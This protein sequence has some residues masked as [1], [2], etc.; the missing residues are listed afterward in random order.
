[1]QKYLEKLYIPP[2]IKKIKID[3]GLS[4]NA[5]ISHKLLEYEDD[6]F[7]FG[8]EPN[9]DSIDNI[10]NGNLKN[11][12]F[13]VIFNTKNINR[14]FILPIAL[15]NVTQKKNVLFHKTIID[16]GT[17]SLYKPI[18]KRL[19]KYDTT[20]VEVFSLKHFFDLFDW[21][22]FPYI[23]WI[24]ID[25]QGADL[26]IIKSAKNYLKERVVYVTLEPENTQY[27]NINQNTIEN[28][29]DYILSNNFIY[30]NHPNTIDPTYLN[31]K[32]IYLKDTVYL[33]QW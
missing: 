29:S 13:P 9:I 21:N 6:V 12:N 10:K 15:D 27:E 32:F 23:E 28:I 2:H 30:I 14:L 18:D 25:A 22:R 17:S 7:I 8:F 3:I 5:P 4:V 16:P 26:N 1:M 19:G 20:Y 11:Y 31:K 33:C 24:K